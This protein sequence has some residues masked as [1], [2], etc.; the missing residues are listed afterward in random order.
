MNTVFT[1]QNLSTREKIC[2]HNC[3]NCY[4]IYEKLCVVENYDKISYST[5]KRKIYAK[6]FRFLN[7]ECVMCN[8][9]RT[10]EMLCVD[11]RDLR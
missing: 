1:L 3:K 4:L 11:I 6:P 5:F 10:K 2:F 7:Y 9:V 8:I